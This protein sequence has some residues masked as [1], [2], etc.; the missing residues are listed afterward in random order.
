MIKIIN[1]LKP[2]IKSFAEILTYAIRQIVCEIQECVKIKMT[3][4][5]ILTHS[6]VL[7]KKLSKDSGTI[8]ATYTIS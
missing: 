7:S 1:C 5:F 4:L 8:N 3:Y 6:L 2:N